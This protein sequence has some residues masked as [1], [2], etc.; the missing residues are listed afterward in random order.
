MVNTTIIA[1]GVLFAPVTMLAGAPITFALLTAGN[2]AAT[3][4]AWYL[5]LRRTLGA[6][7]FAAASAP[8]SAAS[9][10]AWSRRPTATCT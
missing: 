10:R 7:R 2:L 4:I 6:R 3:A 9:G 8:R 5:L 1:I